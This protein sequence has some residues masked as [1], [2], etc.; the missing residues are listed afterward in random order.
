MDRNMAYLD[1]LIRGALIAPV[2]VVL[3]WIAGFAT[4]LG[5]VLVA[6]AAIMLLT[7]IVGFCPLYALVHVRTNQPQ[8]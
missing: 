5:I 3:A 7:A 1:R 6:I 4:W 8:E 2:L